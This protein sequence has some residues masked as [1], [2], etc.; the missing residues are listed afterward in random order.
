M[1]DFVANDG[2]SRPPCFGDPS[3]T[4][5]AR[6]KV[7][8][9]AD[10]Q[11][12]NKRSQRVNYSVFTTAHKGFQI[13]DVL[14]AS[15]QAQLPKKFRPLFTTIPNITESNI[16]LIGFPHISM[17]DSNNDLTTLQH[18]INKSIDD[19]DPVLRDISKKVSLQATTPCQN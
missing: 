2:D 13:H 5:E 8:R 12:T 4:R 17:A 18:T 19:L 7:D 1:S 11:V 10:S 16:D 15:E 9:Q 3:L 14:A 6:R